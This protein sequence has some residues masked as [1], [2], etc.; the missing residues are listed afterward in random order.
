MSAHETQLLMQEIAQKERE[1]QH[2]AETPPFPPPPQERLLP[3]VITSALVGVAM[4]I[5]G[6]VCFGVGGFIE[7]RAAPRTLR[8]VLADAPAVSWRHFRNTSCHVWVT[9]LG[10][11]EIF[12]DG[13]VIYHGFGSVVHDHFSNVPI[14]DGRHY[15][16]DTDRSVLIDLAAGRAELERLDN[17][18]GTCGPRI[19]EDLVEVHP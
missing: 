15:D 4:A 8:A 13:R 14:Y 10:A 12:C 11:A 7:E 9:D 17:C 3:A 5:V 2:R 6:A 1:L 19:L 18:E 16:H